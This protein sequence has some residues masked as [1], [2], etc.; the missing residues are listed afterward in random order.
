MPDLIEW[1]WA[2]EG[3]DLHDDNT[4]VW[5]EDLGPVAFASG[6]GSTQTLD[7]FVM[8]G[9]V[10]PSMPEQMLAELTAAVNERLGLR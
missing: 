1:H 5:Y 8:H 10:S 3:V 6:A 9:P 2:H 4:L 7:E